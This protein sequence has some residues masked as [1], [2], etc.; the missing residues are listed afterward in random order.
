MQV[1]FL[2]QTFYTGPFVKPLGGADLSW[3]AGFAVASGMYLAGAKRGFAR[4][5][6]P[7]PAAAPQD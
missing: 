4:L 1:P 2:D 6:Q 3:I 5:S 7:A